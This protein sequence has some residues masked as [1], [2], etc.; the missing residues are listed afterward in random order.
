MLREWLVALRVSTPRLSWVRAAKAWLR[1]LVENSSPGRST[2]TVASPSSGPGVNEN[3]SPS[4]Y[5]RL[6]RHSPVR[7][8]AS[9]VRGVRYRGWLTVKPAVTSEELMSKSS[10]G[11]ST[12]SA[13]LHWTRASSS[14]PSPVSG[15]AQ[16]P[17][18]RWR[19][20]VPW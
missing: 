19:P 13:S 17:S 6:R 7:K 14:V 20:S 15:S 18:T 9:R 1:V 2:A 3:P 5:E 10:K 4:R 12:T 16:E 11:S 8:A